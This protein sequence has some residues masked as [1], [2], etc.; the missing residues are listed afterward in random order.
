MHRV[1]TTWI[2]ALALAA[3][4][5]AENLSLHQA[6]TL[7]RERAHDVAAAEARS[8][9]S[10]QQLRQAKAY[11]LPHLQ[12]HEIW[13]RTDSPAEAFALQLNQE[14][15]SFGE[16]VSGDPNRP[17]PVENALTRFELSLPI[18]TGGE[19]TGRVRQAELN[20]A[21]AAGHRTWSE[22]T[23]ALAAAQAYIQLAQAR[24]N[25]ALLQRSLEAVE[26][27]VKLAR[28]YVDQGMLV[29]SELLRAQVEQARIED[30]LAA[31]G[32]QAVVAES[33]LAYRLAMKQ[34]RH[35]EL[36]TLAAPKPVERGLDEWL[37]AATQ[38]ADLGAA[39]S[40][41]EAARLE[42]SVER[43]AR[44]PRLG[45]AARY[46]FNDNSLFGRHG[47]SFALMA[48]AS[49]DLFAGGR[50]RAAV[51]A[52]S[53][54]AKAAEYDL[55]RFTEG[56]Q[57]GVRQAYVEAVS[58]RRRHTTAKAAVAAARETERITEERFRRGL[59]R[60]VDVLDAETARREAEARELTT[61]AQAHLALLELVTKSGLR[62]ESALDGGT[63]AAE[64]SGD[65]RSFAA[66]VTEDGAET[67]DRRGDE[68]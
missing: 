46:D 6:M 30:M 43:A 65:T 19:V 21:A 11:R 29:H 23:A 7:A 1:I 16:F 8:A 58:S 33:N 60:T 50:H 35:F 40:M 52:A 57:L 22:D 5:H 28:S 54:E 25:V 13:M 17:D 39:R 3:P 64:V 14:R 27:H 63:S 51:A 36:A 55:D 68:R 47:E 61:R 62:P 66:A 20:A 32:S 9:A 12:V 48:Q 41:V 15:F 45:I 59:V 24:E 56:I 37:Q 42:A 49:L 2:C 44:L 53:E 18:Y 26:A 31:A 4:L 34:G 10:R 38:R 67:T